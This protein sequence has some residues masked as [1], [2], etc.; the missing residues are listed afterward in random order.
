MIQIVVTFRAERRSYRFPEG[1]VRLGSAPDCDW[2]L[3]FPGVSRLHALAE[4]TAEGRLR[5]RDAGSKNGL[6]AGGVR[7]DEVWLVPGEEIA[8]GHA[9]LRLEASDL[10]DDVVDLGLGPQIGRDVDPGTT[11][12]VLAQS[13]AA[14][15]REALRLVREVA[16]EET[17]TPARRRRYLHRLAGVLGAQTL[18][19]GRRGRGGELAIADLVG[20]LPAD[21][22]LAPLEGLA[23]RAGTR[24]EAG[25]GIWLLAP[26]RSRDGAFLAAYLD[27][28]GESVESWQ[29]LALEFFAERFAGEDRASS[30]PEPPLDP[31]DPLRYP[32]AMIVGSSPAYRGLLDELR[33][34]IRSNLPVLV[35]GETGTGKEMIAS[36][37]HGS[38]P[39]A[40]GPLVPINCAAIPPDLLEAELFGIEAKV[41]TDVSARAGLFERAEHGTLL[42][43]EIGD[44]PLALQSKLLRVLQE[45]EVW[46]IGASKA[47]PVDVR[48]V[49]ASNRDL[50][51][52]VQQQHFRADLY[53][54]LRGLVCRVPALRE[55]REDIPELALGLARRFATEQGKRIAGISRSTLERLEALPWPGNIRQLSNELAAAVLRCPAGGALRLE[56]FSVDLFAVPTTA[57]PAAYAAEV[58]V[59]APVEP[60]SHAERHAQLEREEIREALAAAGGRKEEAAKRLGITR[61]GL[62]KR[63]KRLGLA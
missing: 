29:E 19:G 51:L 25:E 13:K 27:R 6:V 46:R 54:R 61:Q 59:S 38:G 32:P 3:P 24:V 5:L 43:D 44:M 22:S 26:P 47:R 39:N 34:A 56:H 23:A 14:G 10:S 60:P 48:V 40:D 37:L 16:A 18:V 41:A 36:L 50:D 12:E 63:M 53:Y 30:V 4:P 15:A 31:H 9:L 20:V 52:L 62:L 1:E 11:E 33:S 58:A 7:R 35:L 28:A 57:S 45:R 42:L 17:L 2:V 55:R 8:L 49:S 21:A